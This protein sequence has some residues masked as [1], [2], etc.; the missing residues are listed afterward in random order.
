M[1]YANTSPCGGRSLAITRQNAST[2][3]GSNWVPAQRRSSAMASVSDHRLAVGPIGGHGVEGVADGHDAGAE[4]DLVAAQPVRI[5]AAVPALVARADEPGHRTQRGRG[6]QDALADQRVAAHE[7]PLDRVERAGLVEDRVR[8]RRSCRRRGARRRGPP[9]R[10]PRGPCASSRPT[11]SA[12][13]PMSRR[14]TLE[15]GAPLGQRAEQHVARLAAGR[16]AAAALA[17]VHAPV[18][19]LERHGRR[20]RLLGQHHDAERARDLE[21]LAALVQRRRS[22]PRGPASTPSRPGETRTQNSSPPRR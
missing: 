10:A 15:V 11:A 4:R 1:A 17:R 21:A 13:S 8:A 7:A 18:G 2:T 12:S 3:I 6:Q 16:H 14:R 22:T 19:E 20:V 9:R 5:A